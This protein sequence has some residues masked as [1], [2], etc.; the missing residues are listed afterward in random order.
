VALTTGGLSR[1]VG[2][3]TERLFGR[4]IK[5]HLLRDG[6]ATTIVE[7]D[8]REALL[9]HRAPRTTDRHHQHATGYAAAA[10]A[11]E[12]PAGCRMP[13]PARTRFRPRS[14]ARR[15]RLPDISGFVTPP[16]ERPREPDRWVGREERTSR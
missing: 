15:R 16:A 13:P 7:T 2:D 6:A 14:S 3:V 9:G 12:L 4:R 11:Y 8:P 10:L 5:P 1:H